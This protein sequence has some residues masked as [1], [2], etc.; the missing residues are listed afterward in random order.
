M[1]K[2]SFFPL[3]L[4]IVKKYVLLNFIFLFLMSV[5]RFIFCFYYSDLGDFKGLFWHV[6]KAFILGLRFDLVVIAYLNAVIVLTLLITWAFRNKIL[7]KLWVV[8]S[9]YYYIFVYALV[10]IL[11]IFDFGFYSYFQNHINVV[12]FGIFEDDTKALWSTL[13]ENYNMWLVFLGFFALFVIIY[14]LVSYFVKSIDIREF[15]PAKKSYPVFLKSS[16]IAVLIIVNIVT[17]RGSLGLFPLGTYDAAISPNVFINKLALNGINTLQETLEFRLNEDRNYDLIKKVGYEN[18]IEAAFSTFLKKS[19][20]ELDNDLIKD[21]TFRTK[22][23]YGLE[24]NRPNVVVIMMEGFG[25][26]LLRYQSKH[27]NV[28]GE[29]EKH[30]KSDLLFLSFLS[31]DVGTIGSFEVVNL[32]IAKRPKARHVSQSKYAYNDRISGA[33]IPYKNAGYETILMYGGNIAWR[34]LETYASKLGYDHSQGEESMER[35]WERN[36]WG[37]YDEYLYRQ[38]YKR[39]ADNNT[40]P[41][42]I[43]ALTTSN[44][45]PYSLPDSY[46]PLPLEVNGSLEADITGDRKLANLRFQT[47][48]YSNH[49]LGE[50]ITRIKNSKYGDNT[51]IAVTGDHNFWGVFNYTQEKTPYR[52]AVPLYLYI[53]DHLKPKNVD[54]KTPGSHLDIMPTLYNLSLSEAEYISLGQDMLDPKIKHI[55]FNV[56]GIIL[57]KKESVRYYLGTDSHF[58]FLWD[59]KREGMWKSAEENGKSGE[60]IKYYKAVLALSEYIVKY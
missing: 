15:N 31:G 54:L 57:T 53:P 33:A 60:L 39:L 56:D 13:V 21:I 22:K 32:N 23:N 40:K 46:K 10:F 27:F 6:I 41:K 58:N 51:I 7:F 59:P 4:D 45:P 25:S 37:V 55:G 52:Y 35:G 5:H 12:I 48:Q 38:I 42:F 30:F 9:K 29:L 18:N 20:S 43:F 11:L 8:F 16:F 49:K 17:A 26:D 44:H 1:T 14:L 3:V 28:L 19:V 47:Y 24:K 2:G 36:Q 34:N 50:L